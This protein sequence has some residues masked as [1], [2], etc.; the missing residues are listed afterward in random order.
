MAK[1]YPSQIKYEQENP[2]IC[3]R[4]KR[5]E[6]E[7]IK[8][9]VEITGKNESQIMRET[10]FYAEK[11]YSDVYKKG[12]DKGYNDGYDEGN[13]KGKEDWRIWFFCSICGE[14]MFV[15]PDSDSHNAII[16]Y[17]KKSGWG[18]SKC[19]KKQREASGIEN[20]SD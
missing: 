3:F 6:K 18:H 8:Q 17:T 19:Y 2:L 14:M 20:P 7:K 15:D 16:K 12:Y 10:L 1:K 13:D 11:E 5:D 9:I 4:V